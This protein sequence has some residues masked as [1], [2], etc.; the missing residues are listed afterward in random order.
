M[1]LLRGLGSVVVANVRIQGRNKHKGL[2]H[3]RVDTLLVGLNSDHAV[4]RK[5]N[6]CIGKEADRL[7]QVLDQ[8]RF[9]DIELLQ[10]RAKEDCK[11]WSAK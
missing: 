10:Y 6:R 2:V 4:I 9:E 1:S 3:D 11:I 5:G 8:D 7:S